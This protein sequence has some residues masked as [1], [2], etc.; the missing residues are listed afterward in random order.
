MDVSGNIAQRV[1]RL[2]RRDQQRRRARSQGTAQRVRRPPMSPGPPDQSH[3]CDKSGARGTRPPASFECAGHGASPH[4]SPGRF[5]RR[6]KSLAR[7][8]LFPFS[9]VVG[10]CRLRW[11]R[12]RG[13]IITA[14]GE[15]CGLAGASRQTIPCTT[16]HQSVRRR[17]R[18]TQ[19]QRPQGREIGLRHRGAPPGQVFMTS[20]ALRSE[21]ALVLAC[22]CVAGH[23]DSCRICH[24]RD[25]E[26]LADPVQPA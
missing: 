17:H 12:P 11:P 20:R 24:T 3:V 2:Q 19:V 16:V 26:C 9:D 10:A 4:I 18:R 13:S 21:L 15:K 25:P 1:G 6:H 22:P 8:G 23:T 5:L 7:Q 14:P